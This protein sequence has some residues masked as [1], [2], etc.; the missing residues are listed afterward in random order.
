GCACICRIELATESCLHDP[1]VAAPVP[2]VQE[3]HR[4]GCFK[5]GRQAFTAA[6]HLPEN[7]RQLAEC[8][9]NFRFTWKLCVDLPALANVHNV[10]RHLKA[11]TKTTAPKPRS[12]CICHT[13]LPCGTGNMNHRNSVLRV[14][15]AS[16]K[17]HS[18]LET[19]SAR[20]QALGC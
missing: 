3:R 18:A 2:K 11:G 20:E 7:G 5:I 15:Q 8:L 9:D 19:C 16:H 14:T 4:N 10:G 12:N 1:Y 17:R 6:L 13:A